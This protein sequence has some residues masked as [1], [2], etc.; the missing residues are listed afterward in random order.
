[1]QKFLSNEQM[2][3]A[4]A[5]TINN[6]KVP[7]GELMR[8]AGRALADEVEKVSSLYGGNIVVVC[9]GGNNGG[10]GYVCAAEL[11]SR[12]L[13]VAVLDLSDG[14]YSPDCAAARSAYKG[15]YTQSAEG[16]VVVD[17][18]FG[19]GLCREVSEGYARVINEI[20]SGSAYVVS[21]D[22]PSGL[23]GD[24]GQILGTAVEADLTVAM[25]E[26]KLGHVLGDGPDCCG[27]VVRADIGIAAEG[28]YAFSYDD[29]EVAAFFPQRR[30]NT[31]K[32][33]YGS[34]CLIAG[35]SRYPG[36]A[37]LCLSGALRSGCGYVKLSSSPEVTNALAAA[38]PQAIYLSSPDYSS[39]AMAIGPGCGDAPQL[40]SAITAI[41]R[42]YRGK[43][44]I[45]ADGINSLAACGADVL[46]QKE[47]GVILTPHAKEFARIAGTDV[48][49][50]LSDPVG[51]AAGFAKRYGVT[52]VLK[53]A[54]TVICDGVRTAINARG[55][56]ALAKAGS[57]DMLAGFMCGTVARGLAPFEGAVCAAYIMGAAAELA[58]ADV[59]EYCATASD[60]LQSI[61]R[62]IKAVKTPS[63]K[64]V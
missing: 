46:A 62:A 19:T 20:N 39:Q 47:C 56:S 59:T 25:G 3:A 16:D 41:I 27:A 50:V 6:L 31:H 35:S 57:G 12:G 2:R 29:E 24:N 33:S 11:A 23:N 42:S 28:D 54:G 18:I 38:Y 7:S 49:D 14:K 58:A 10:D 36:A 60:I 5:H 52:V 53:G 34:A 1:M 48:R 51:H 26:Y 61:P 44:I 8:R 64:N 15:A 45:D 37:A 55:C 40:Y 21:A 63:Y 9:G 13:K 43:L 22:I 4:D 30:R 32:G 17:C